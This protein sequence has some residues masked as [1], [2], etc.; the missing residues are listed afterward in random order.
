M[1][2]SSNSTHKRV[3]SVAY[4]AA[5]L[6]VSERTIWRLIAAKKIKAVALSTR[7]KG[8]PVDEVT[9]IATEGVSGA[10]ANA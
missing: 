2:T 8:I 3:V 10:D 1:I 6:G 9:R 5:Q 4:A 7:R